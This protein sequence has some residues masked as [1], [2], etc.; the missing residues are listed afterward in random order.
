VVLSRGFNVAMSK[1]EQ[2]KFDKL[3]S[4]WAVSDTIKAAEVDKS[5]RH[6]VNVSCSAMRLADVLGHPPTLD[7]ELAFVLGK[8]EGAKNAV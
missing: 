1:A 7:E 3:K 6:A 4:D 5:A 8:I 2:K